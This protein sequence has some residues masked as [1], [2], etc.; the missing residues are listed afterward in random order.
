[1]GDRSGLSAT[2]YPELSEVRIIIQ[3]VL[4]AVW[5]TPSLPASLQQHTGHLHSS[6]H[7][8]DGTHP[9]DTADHGFC[10]GFCMV[11]C[12]TFALVKVT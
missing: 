6:M 3:G 7:R 2:L 12:M 1:M 5:Q 10:M 11:G 4:G 9:R 8:D